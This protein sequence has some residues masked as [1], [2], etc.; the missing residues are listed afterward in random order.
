MSPFRKFIATR[1]PKFYFMHKANGD[2]P[3]TLLDL[4]AGNGSPSRTMSIFPACTYHGVD[5]NYD[6]SYTEADVKA[7]KRFFEMDLTKLGF[8][9]IPDDHYDH[10]NM[11]HIIEHLHNGEKVLE[12]IAPKLKK[13][14]HIYIEYPGQK[15]TTLPSM[16]GSLN[17]KDDPT[18]V[19]VY[20]YKE[21]SEVLR[22]LGFEILSAGTRRS[23]FYI[24]S[25]PFLAIGSW[26]K[27]GSVQGAVFWDLLGFAEY[28]YARKIK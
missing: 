8:N 9:E 21:L 4:G 23:W 15:S 3:F 1:T 16:K 7:L 26:R 14:G 12:G 13:G 11:A 2:R 17:F 5:L 28:V 27:H 10:I 24:L 18:H 19:R 22:G 25:M 20:N 6:Y